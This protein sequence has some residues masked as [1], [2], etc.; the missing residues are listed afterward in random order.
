M[1]DLTGLEWAF[2]CPEG[3]TDDEIRHGYENLRLRLEL[4]LAQHPITTTAAIRAER[5]LSYYCRLK[6]AE[7]M[8][9]GDAEDCGFSSPAEEQQVNAFLKALLK[10]WDDVIIRSK[11]SGQEAALA[12]ERKFKGI[13]VEIIQAT[14][15]P[16]GVRNELAERF[17]RTV[18]AAG[19]DHG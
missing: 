2:A 12:V 19:L 5:I 17:T 6:Q 11:P 16:E 18:V 8:P 13:F 9:Y 1:A 4:E 3:V 7:K 14:E 15:M 10:D